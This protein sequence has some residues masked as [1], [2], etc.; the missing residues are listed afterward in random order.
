MESAWERPRKRPDRVY[1]SR[2]RDRVAQL[3]TGVREVVDN[4]PPDASAH[5]RTSLQRLR[6]SRS[7]RDAMSTLEEE[8]EALFERLAPGLIAHPLPVR[9]R[10]QALTWVGIAAGTAAALDE[11]EAI[12]LFVPGVDVA[13][14][15]SL[16]LVLTAA[17]LALFVEMYVAASVRVHQLRDAGRP[18]DPNAVTHDVLRAMTGRDDATFTKAAT[19][20]MSRRMLR[21]W[22]R[23][24]VPFVGI[25]F[26][27][28]DAQKTVRAITRMPLPPIRLEPVQGR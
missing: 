6:Q 24:I 28:L 17:F 22:G 27:S 21:R 4:L 15:P 3:R 23:S 2:A 11:I 26:S 8:L 16:P 20:S 7:P 14:V 9:T 10:R 25:G 1:L 18:V 12:G 19:K 13:A 5:L